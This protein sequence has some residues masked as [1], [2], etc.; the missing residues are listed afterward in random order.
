MKIDFFSKFLPTVNSKIALLLQSLSLQMLFFSKILSTV[1][2]K[3][4]LLLQ[5]LSVQMLL[6]VFS[7]EKDDT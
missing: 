1:N 3:I 5:S 6:K 4:A 7:E 2:S